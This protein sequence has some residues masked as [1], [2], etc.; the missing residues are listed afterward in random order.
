MLECPP[1][2]RKWRRT[3]SFFSLPPQDIFFLFSFETFT[4]LG[5]MKKTFNYFYIHFSIDN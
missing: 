2:R 5:K 1:Y 4:L 3:F